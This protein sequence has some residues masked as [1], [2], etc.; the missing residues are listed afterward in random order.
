M[1]T[2]ETLEIETEIDRNI[3]LPDTQRQVKEPCVHL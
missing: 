2:K 1:K 3:E